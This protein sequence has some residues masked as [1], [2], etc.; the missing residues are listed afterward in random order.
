MGNCIFN[1]YIGDL[2]RYVCV[3]YLYSVLWIVL[4]FVSFVSPYYLWFI[5]K[6]S[7]DGSIG[8]KLSSF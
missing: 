5:I 8:G 2:E 6:F 7:E 3:I 1:S 4:L